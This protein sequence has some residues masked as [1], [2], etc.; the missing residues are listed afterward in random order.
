VTP[1]DQVIAAC[2][3][4]KDAGYQIAL[5]DFVD[6]DEYAPLVSLADIIKVD[7]LAT[8]PAGRRAMVDRYAPKGIRLLA[9]KV[10]TPEMFREAVDEGYAYFQGYFFARPSML[11]ARSAPEFRLTYLRLLQEASRPD[12]DLRRMAAIISQDVTLSYRLLRRINSAYYGI[13]GTVSSILEAVRLLGVEDIRRWASLL[14]LA[15]LSLNKPH[16]LVVESALRARFCESLA[17]DVG[18]AA[19]RDDLFILGMF[20]L[21]DAMLD[22]P[23]SELVSE[24]PLTPSVKAALLGEPNAIRRV[25]DCAVAYLSGDW[26]N[27]AAGVAALGL[28]EETLPLRYRDALMWVEKALPSG[29]SDSV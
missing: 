14:F 22:R 16:E 1:D 26:A 25:F 11:R 20:S 17:G 21:L 12:V 19:Q 2:Q 3:R 9:E 15:T 24:L 18:L 10:E 4:L 5:D 23:L 8:T 29:A 27:M 13:R 28:G 6:A 7:V